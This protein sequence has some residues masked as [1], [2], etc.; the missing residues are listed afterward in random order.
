M[1]DILYDQADQDQNLVAPIIQYVLGSSDAIDQARLN[2]SD[3][4]SG[5]DNYPEFSF[6]R[7]S[8]SSAANSNKSMQAFPV[9]QGKYLSLIHI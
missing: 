9:E 1:V 7:V 3:H 5:D 6:G 8:G 2:N 4:T